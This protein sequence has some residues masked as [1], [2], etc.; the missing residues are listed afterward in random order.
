MTARELL[1]ASAA[2]LL[3]GTW[4]LE[5]GLGISGMH[6]GPWGTGSLLAPWA[7]GTG[8]GLPRTL[9]PEGP[10]EGLETAEL[11]RKTAVPERHVPAVRANPLGKQRWALPSGRFKTRVSW[12]PWEMAHSTRGTWHASPDVPCP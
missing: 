8:P 11:P 3:R 5:L 2:A 7:L 6:D 4:E 9:R 12:Q 1:G 10:H